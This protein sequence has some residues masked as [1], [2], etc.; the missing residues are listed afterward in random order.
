MPRERR[1][2]RW[3]WPGNG[4]NA[5]RRGSAR[6]FRTQSSTPSSAAGGR[7]SGLSDCCACGPRMLGIEQET[8][9]GTYPFAP[10]Y[11]V[12]N[13][14][15]IHFA[16]EGVG[17][18]VVLLHGD[19]TW[20]YLYRYFIPPLARRRRCIVPDHMGMGK[21]E[22]PDAPHPYRLS[23]HIANLEALLLAL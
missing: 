23:H 11:R 14:V 16:D 12:V 5:W 4:R 6:R 8:F 10:P 17:E 13:G 21:S 2:P 1:S 20:G 15:R 18:P 3:N 9:D 7:E 19:P 22:T